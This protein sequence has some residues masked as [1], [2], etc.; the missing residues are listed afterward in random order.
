[1]RG[2]APSNVCLS[3]EQDVLLTPQSWHRQQCFRISDDTRHGQRVR[4]TWAVE[5]QSCTK[6]IIWHRI[7]PSFLQCNGRA[8]Q[9]CNV[10]HVQR[11]SV[12][13]CEPRIRCRNDTGM[14]WRHVSAVEGTAETVDDRICMQAAESTVSKLMFERNTFALVVRQ[15]QSFAIFPWNAPRGH[16]HALNTNPSQITLS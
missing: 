3:L 6:Q 11:T 12:G 1:M 13:F 14:N 16:D 8:L 10:L 5:Q 9:G 2:H 4:N 15:T 7:V